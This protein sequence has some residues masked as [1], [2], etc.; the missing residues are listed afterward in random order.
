VMLLLQ[1]FDVVVVPV[2]LL[3]LSSVPV[4]ELWCC[5]CSCDVVAA[6]LWFIELYEDEG[7]GIVLLLVVVVVVVVVW[8]LMPSLKRY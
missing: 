7:D 4:A 5:D 6:N 2:M 3:L 8:L 1:S